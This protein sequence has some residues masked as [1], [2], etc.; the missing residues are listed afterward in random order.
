MTID[1]QPLK[2][3]ETVLLVALQAVK[4][5]AQQTKHCHALQNAAMIIKPA[6]IINEALSLAAV[7]P[8]LRKDLA[9][10]IPMFSGPS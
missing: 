10:H 5:P 2:H 8:C 6:A 4:D 7:L 9:V 3:R 1:K